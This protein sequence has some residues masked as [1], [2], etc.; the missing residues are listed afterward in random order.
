MKRCIEVIEGLDIKGISP[1]LEEDYLRLFFLFDSLVEE[2]G[3]E[4]NAAVE[5][6][7]RIQKETLQ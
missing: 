6:F 3:F 4:S 5:L 1:P 7:Q 2:N